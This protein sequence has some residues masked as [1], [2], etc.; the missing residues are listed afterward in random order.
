MDVLTIVCLLVIRILEGFLQLLRLTPQAEALQHLGSTV[1]L[2]LTA[3]LRYHLLFDVLELLIGEVLHE[4]RLKHLQY[5][6]SV[7]I[8]LLGIEQLRCFLSAEFCLTQPLHNW[9]S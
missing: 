3:M 1:P 6:S 9:L 7:Y 5:I 4:H 2:L 8:G